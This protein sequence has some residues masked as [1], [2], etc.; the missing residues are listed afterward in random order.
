MFMV[1]YLPSTSLQKQTRYIHFLQ[2]NL[3][4]A[5]N[6]EKKKKKKN[7]Y[8]YIDRYMYKYRLLFD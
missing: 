1:R 8:I 2:Q 4:Q 6:E 3:N 5:K 7:I